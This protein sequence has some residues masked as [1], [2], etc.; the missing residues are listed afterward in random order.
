MAGISAGGGALTNCAGGGAINL[1]PGAGAAVV[2][3][4][5]SFDD[6]GRVGI[7]GGP[8]VFSS[9]SS[10]ATAAAAACDFDILVEPDRRGESIG[11]EAP[12]PA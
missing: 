8:F 5:L 6:V 9:A 12:R 4:A 11:P 1:L 2:G 7:S 3:A 10:S